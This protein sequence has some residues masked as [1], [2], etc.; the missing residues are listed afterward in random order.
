MIDRS[1]GFIV[2]AS[3]VVCSARFASY[4][5]MHCTDASTVAGFG[6]GGLV[7]GVV[8]GLR[9]ARFVRK[10][11]GWWWKVVLLLGAGAMSVLTAICCVEA[12]RVWTPEERFRDVVGSSPPGRVVL[13]R[14][15]SFPMSE[16]RWGFL[17]E[18]SD[19][20]VRQFWAESLS[21]RSEFRTAED[22][23]SFFKRMGGSLGF[24]GVNEDVLLGLVGRRGDY[25]V[26]LARPPAGEV[27]QVIVFR[28]FGF[29]IGD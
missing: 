7:V 12:F 13:A 6:I 15:E 4:A 28:Q 3:S 18:C 19:G 22:S 29:K 24:H 5:A 8:V 25:V 21:D 17:M 14:G 27:V 9:V 16:E 2:L 26:A 11:A 1:A 23:P 10:G 20:Q